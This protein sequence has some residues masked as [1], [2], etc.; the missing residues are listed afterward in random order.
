M[1][2]KITF[3]KTSKEQLFDGGEREFYELILKVPTIDELS[4]ATSDFYSNPIERLE[5]QVDSQ[6][7][8]QIKNEGG[9][10]KSTSFLENY[11]GKDELNLYYALKSEYLV[12]VSFGEIQP[13]RFLMYLEGIWLVDQ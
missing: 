3:V 9:F 4:F 2:N 11:V 8:N 1:F 10:A 13:A 7:F 5:E 12:I 6:L